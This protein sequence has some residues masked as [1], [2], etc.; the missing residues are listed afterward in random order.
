MLGDGKQFLKT[1]DVTKYFIIKT[2]IGPIKGPIVV[3]ILH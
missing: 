2:T 1:L 3:F